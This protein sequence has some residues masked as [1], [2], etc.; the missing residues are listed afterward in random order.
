MSSSLPV[1]VII[2]SALIL[3]GILAVIMIRKKMKEGK[4]VEIDYNA[5]FVMG[6]SFLPLGIV[7]TVLIN[8]GFIG[9]AGLGLI[10]IIIGLSHRERWRR[11][12]MG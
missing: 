3:L 9:L 5:F 7:L 8:P 2:L 10:S 1:V 12:R 6:I 11:K 4:P